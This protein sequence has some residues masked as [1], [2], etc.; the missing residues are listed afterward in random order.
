MHFEV[1]K[2]IKFIRNGEELPKNW[3]ELVIVP[4]YKK[5]ERIYCSKY[6]GILR[7]ATTYTILS[8]TLLSRLTLYVGEIIGDHQ[9]GFRRNRSTT[10]HTCYIRQILEKKWE[11]SE[12]VHQLFLDFI[13]AYGAV[14]RKVLFNILTE[15]GIP[16]KEVMLIKSV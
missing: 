13:K 14:R 12:A 9:Y 3:E 6:R 7:L 8:N 15:F 16:I 1:R 11:Y 4:I 5:D 2:L 10:D